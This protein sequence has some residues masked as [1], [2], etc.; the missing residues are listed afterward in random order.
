MVVTTMK[1]RLLVVF[2]AT[3]LLSCQEQISNLDKSL[4]LAGNNRPELEKVLVHYSQNAEDSLKY[5][6]ACFLIENM[7]GHYS[8]EDVTYINEFYNEVDSVAAIYKHLE[9]DEKEA[10]YKQVVSKYSDTS[11]YVSDIQVITADYLITNIDSAF[12]VW[13]KGEWSLHINFDDFCEYI[14]PYKVCEGQILDNWREYLYDYCNGTSKK[15]HNCFLL[16]NAAYNACETVNNNLKDSLHPR[17]TNEQSVPIRRMNTLTKIPCGLCDD[18]NILAL[19]VMR[20]KGLPVIMDFTP[21]WPFQSQ[22]HSWNVLIETSGKKVVFE[23]VGSNPANPHKEE[24][25]MAKAFRKTYAI[26][27]EIRKIHA[28]EKYVPPTF[29]EMCMKDVSTEY[30]DTRDVTLSVESP[31]KYEYAYLA[32]FDNANWIPIHWGKIFNRDK[33]TFEKMGKR[34]VY[35]PIFYGAMGMKSF[36]DPVL[37]TISGEQIKLTPDTLR[38]QTLTLKRKYPPFQP[39]YE[40]GERIIGGKIQIASSPS[41]KDSLT[42][43]TINKFGLYTEEI[44]LTDFE[45]SAR[46]WR[47]YPPDGVHCN[48]AELLFYEKDSINPTMGKIIGTEGSYRKDTDKYAKEAAFDG[49]ALTFFD[50]PE[51]NGCWVGMDFGKPVKIDRIVYMPRND[52]NC[53]EIGDEYELLYWGNNKWQ[54]LGEKVADNVALIY[55]DCPTNALFLLRNHT[56]G[57]EERI[58]TYENDKQ[59]WW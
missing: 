16:E 8:H 32:V 34:I 1:K 56:K 50:A 57:K 58:F 22:G 13:Q 47:Y 54:S 23:G 29:R 49:D 7:P 48:I 28:V 30:F 44:D 59:V 15:H 6:A 27:E 31:H 24:H 45:N 52:G 41:F 33:V 5:R 3:L 4:E 10:L 40:I 2:F 39:I 46:Y 25:R 21:Q 9:Q 20:A 11:N 18:Y 26:N 37:L 38:K 53:I 42:L 36:S 14:L 43:H 17:L 51:S 55:E 35:L 19:A 12:S